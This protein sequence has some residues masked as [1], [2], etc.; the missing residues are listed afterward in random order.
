[1]EQIRKK[2]V[3]QAPCYM[4]SIIIYSWRWLSL[5]QMMMCE[6][7]KYNEALTL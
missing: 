4:E 6:R 1:M 2:R 7:K 3:V 5:D